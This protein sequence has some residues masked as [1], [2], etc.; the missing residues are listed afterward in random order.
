[1]RFEHSI[2]NHTQQ[3]QQQS[4]SNTHFPNKEIDFY[5]WRQLHTTGILFF[6]LCSE[7]EMCACVCSDRHSRIAI[8]L[9]MMRFLQVRVA[10]LL[11][12]T[13]SSFSLFLSGIASIICE[14]FSFFWRFCCFV[15]LHYASAVCLNIWLNWPNGYQNG[16]HSSTF[17]IVCVYVSALILSPIRLKISG[18]I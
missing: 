12:V 18:C 11:V 9:W 10:F 17:L 1:M 13:S 16:M 4:T 3:Q 5:N 2:Q 15:F 14:M 7:C 6:N 8:G